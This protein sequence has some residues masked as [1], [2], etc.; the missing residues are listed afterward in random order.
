MGIV[1]L[2]KYRGRQAFFHHLFHLNFLTVF[3]TPISIKKLEN[4]ISITDR[5]KIELREP[6][7]VDFKYIGENINSNDMI[8]LVE[9]CI[10]RVY[11]GEKVYEDFTK[12]DRTNFLES[13]TT[14]QFK[15][16][17]E[18]YDASPKLKHDIKV[19]NPK[20]NIESEVSL[21]GLNNFF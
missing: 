10:V 11:D 7:I 14:S 3:A 15:K 1:T 4:I 21:E 20:T 17:T 6:S 18:F 5:I 19:K 13:L 16:L 9:N 2:Q 12:E 8:S